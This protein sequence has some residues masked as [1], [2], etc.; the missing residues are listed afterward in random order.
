MRITELHYHPA[1]HPG[2]TDPE[3]LEFIE[4][5]NT[6]SQTVSLAG[7]QIT[8]FA[9]DAVHVCAAS[10]WPRGE[11]IIVARNPAVVPI[12][13][14]QRHQRRAGRLRTA[15]LSNGGERVAL[16]G[17]LGETLQDFTYDDVAP[18][19][20]APD[21]GGPSLEIIDPLGDPTI[22]SNWRASSMPADRRGPT[23]H[24]TR[25]G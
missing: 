23:A 10:T 24:P 14:R 12:G 15:N 22:P 5:L 4:L 2:V 3:D 8:Q 21:G 25:R 9:S 19:P 20:T 16:L 7:V 6:G 18:W 11:R 17:P 13:L 1:D